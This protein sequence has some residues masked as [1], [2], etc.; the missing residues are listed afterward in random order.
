VF[1]RAAHHG[2][3]G[4][5]ASPP[6]KPLFSRWC[7]AAGCVW[8][9]RFD[10]IDCIANGVGKRPM[11]PAQPVAREAQS[12]TPIASWR[13]KAAA[14]FPPAFLP[15]RGS[16]DR[17]KSPAQG[18]GQFCAWHPPVDGAFLGKKGEHQDGGGVIRSNGHHLPV[19][20]VAPNPG[21]YGII[22]FVDLEFP[23]FDQK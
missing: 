11:L 14:H 4:R 16:G 20:V 7:G 21:A 9:N 18:R 22:L 17:P 3:E 5:A 12:V 10:T 23:I 6:D 1:G 19:A 2:F 15:W 8:F 13:H